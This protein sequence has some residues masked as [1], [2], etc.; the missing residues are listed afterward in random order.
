MHHFDI[1]AFFVVFLM[2]YIFVFANVVMI[3]EIVSFFLISITTI[4]KE[5]NSFKTL[6]LQ[7][8]W[9]PNLAGW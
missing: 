5:T 3:S 9:L 6:I 7:C 2:K 4:V 8:L 1:V